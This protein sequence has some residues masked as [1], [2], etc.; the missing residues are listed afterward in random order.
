MYHKSLTLLLVLT[1]ATAIAQADRYTATLAQ[2]LTDK[3]EF[4]A[5]GNIWRCSGAICVLTSDPKDAVSLRS[6]RELKR[7]VGT[8][9]AYGPATKPLDPDKL[10]NCNADR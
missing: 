9:S 8:L 7:L 2:P 3:K 10:S 6:C 1:S 4:I 5:N